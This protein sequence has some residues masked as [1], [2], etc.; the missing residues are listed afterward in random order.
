MYGILSKNEIRHY[1]KYFDKK[2]MSDYARESFEKL[3]L[4]NK[5]MALEYY[6][7]S[8]VLYSQTN[9]AWYSKLVWTG[10]GDGSYD[11][12]LLFAKDQFFVPFLSLDF[13][14]ERIKLNKNQK[15]Q[16]VEFGLYPQ[17]GC[18]SSSNLFELVDSEDKELNYIYNDDF[19]T[20]GYKTFLKKSQKYR[21]PDDCY[22][23]ILRGKKCDL[24]YFKNSIHYN[25]F[26]IEPVEW[27]VDIEKNIM[28]PRL[29]L[30]SNIPF[31][32]GKLDNQN[33]DGIND[34]T[35]IYQFIKDC[36]IPNVLQ[37][38]KINSKNYLSQELQIY[39]N[40]KSDNLL[41][42]KKKELGKELNK[43]LEEISDEKI[44]E[45]F[46]NKEENLQKFCIDE[47]KKLKK[48]IQNKLNN[49]KKEE[50]KNYKE[51]IIGFEKE[52][53]NKFSEFT[54]AIKDKEEILNYVKKEF[55]N[56]S[57]EEFD[58]KM[59]PLIDEH[60]ASI[61][62]MKKELNLEISKLVS[63]YYNE[64]EK[65]I[66][67]LVDNSNKNIELL[68]DKK[69]ELKKI[70]SDFDKTK[71][72]LTSDV[73]L[74]LNK[75]E[76]KKNNIEEEITEEVIKKVV[77]I[78][79]VKEVNIIVDNIKKKGV[80]GLFHQD[81]EAILRLV[82]I[83]LP[84]FLV[85]PAGCGK[86]VILKQCSSVLDKK[87]Y[88]QN[89]ANED[90]KLLGF[91][92]ANGIYHKTPF[93][94]AFTNGGLLMLD[95]MDNANASVLLKLNSA[96][97]SGN[98]FYMTFPNGETKQANKDF[99]VVAAAN[100]FGRGENQ[101]YCGRNNLDGATLDRYFIY[102]LDYDKKLEEALVKNK[103][104]LSL[105]WNVREIIEKNDIKHTVST[106]AI[107]N[108]DKI[109]SS[110]IIGKGTFTIGNAFDGTLIKGLDK[111][112]LAIIVSRLTSSDYYTQ[113][114]I[115]YLKNNYDV[116]KD[117]YEKNKYDEYSYQ[118]T[119]K[120]NGWY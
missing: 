116:S 20:D 8:D 117:E 58:K 115:K 87:F 83:N 81:F 66:N 23:S 41:K 95:E 56:I 77:E 17:T 85:G 110:N 76:T 90:H 1:K 109:I 91:V 34:H 12:T 4:N 74:V 84:V 108:M 105:Y 118:K 107:L 97:G 57:K 113:E 10:D 88:Y 18:K 36:F 33:Y 6:G 69:E 52:I 111:D 9:K 100:T 89:D 96:I 70:I 102:N 78:N 120:S 22:P 2:I 32:K 35:T 51:K 39:V 65:Q 99:Q 15:I 61:K 44:N 16:I 101:I 19:S 40:N 55:D 92:D 29:I 80:K 62:K 46:K 112:D 25:C 50:L 106:R 119:R 49:Y 5:L 21:I 48:E 47:E 45:L 7:T 3:I 37:N 103:E 64:F 13:L 26:L 82:S 98:D 54:E 30:F 31:L 73:D 59:L 75:I 27:I 42:E 60:I 38:E 43:Y 68:E 104:I 63:K 14:P 86:N 94:E 28:F 72:K 71:E 24:I 93:Y 53:E 67:K 11:A 114:F 79:P